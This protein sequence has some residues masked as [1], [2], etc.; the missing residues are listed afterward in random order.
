MCHQR[1][2]Y[3]RYVTQ[4]F[5]GG[6]CRWS[7]QRQCARRSQDDWTDHTQRRGGWFWWT[8]AVGAHSYGC[9]AVRRDC[10][11]PAH[12]RSCVSHIAQRRS[13]HST[14][15][16]HLLLQQRRWPAH[17]F[18]HEQL[19]PPRTERHVLSVG[20]RRHST[21]KPHN[22]TALSHGIQYSLIES[23]VHSECYCVII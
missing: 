16:L 22:S 20:S 11:V 19:L 4:C 3:R 13:K 12:V 23:P 15:L 5:V 1:A 7:D 6:R 18:V 17:L 2:R 8:A 9:D 10:G 14:N 21:V